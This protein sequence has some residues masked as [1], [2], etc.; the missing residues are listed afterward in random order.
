MCNAVLKKKISWKVS[1]R[2]GIPLNRSW[3]IFGSCF[4]G[5]GRGGRSRQGGLGMD[6]LMFS[7]MF[8]VFR[9]ELLA[10]SKKFLEY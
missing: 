8:F 7:T 2:I 10:T 3:N 5:L 1:I 4:S 6:V 9:T